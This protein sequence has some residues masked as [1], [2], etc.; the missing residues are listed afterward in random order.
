VRLDL[1][2]EGDVRIVLMELVETEHAPPQ[3]VVAKER[4][5]VLPHG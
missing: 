3:F 1:G 5:E 2:N 4:G